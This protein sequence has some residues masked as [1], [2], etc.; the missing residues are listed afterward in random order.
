MRGG[1]LNPK[2]RRRSCLRRT[3]VG[4]VRAAG[5]RSSVFPVQVRT[6]EEPDIEA[7]LDL[8]A[9]VAGE[10]L[11]ATSALRPARGARP[12]GTCSRAT[13]VRSVADDAARR[14]DSP[15]SSGPPSRSSGCSCGPT[16]AAPGH[17]RPLV[18]AA[19]GG[20]AA[21]A[22][23]GSSFTCSL[24]N[25]AAIALYEKH[26][27][28]MRGTVRKAY[29]RR[30]GVG[31]GR[32]PHGEGAWGGAGDREEAEVEA[33]S[34]QGGGRAGVFLMS[35]GRGRGDAPVRTTARRARTSHLIGRIWQCADTRPD[36]GG[37]LRVPIR[38]R[39]ERDST[40]GRRPTRESRVHI[41]GARVPPAGFSPCVHG[42]SA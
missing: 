25:A 17:R 42:H 18:L 35:S 34:L 12:G 19:I 26:G 41:G 10:A 20:R 16:A 24:G 28:G 32:H 15:R 9:A 38:V 6:L 36:F 29:R 27:F 4:G 11:V 37:M 40:A 22:R 31:V 2:S 39:F 14:S 33:V 8:F 5:Q 7:A 1:Y 13:R 23:S 30:S 21:A 3:A